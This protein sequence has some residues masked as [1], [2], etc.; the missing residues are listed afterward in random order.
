[1]EG[2]DTLPRRIFL[3]GAR[4]PHA[5]PDGFI[6]RAGSVLEPRDLLAEAAVLVAGPPW[7]GKT[8]VAKRLSR[9]LQE[10]TSFSWLTSFDERESGA[11]EPLWW[12][13]WL[14]GTGSAV[15]IIDA[16]D[17]DARK[18]RQCFRI[19]RSIR[20]LSPEIRAR[21]HLIAFCRINE[22]PPGFERDLEEIFGA[23]RRVRLAGLDRDAAREHVGPGRFRRVCEL[24]RG[25]DLQP[26]APYPAVLTWLA[27]RGEGEILTKP[28]VWEGVLKDLLREKR[29]DPA[30][31]SFHVEIGERLG[32]ACKLAALTTFCGIGDVDPEE[33][34]ERAFPETAH[35]FAEN[36]RAVREAWRGSLFERFGRGYRFCQDHVRQWLTAFAL[37]EM[38]PPQLKPLLTLENGDPDPS[39]EGV[40][41]LLA[42]ISRHP[43]VKD[44]LVAAHGGL[45]VG[46]TPWSLHEASRAL[47][48]LQ[49]L[50]RSSPWGLS[51]WRQ[52]GLKSFGRVHGMGEEIAR[53]LELDLHPT[54]QQLLLELA[55]VIDAPE[56]VVPAAQILQD[57]RQEE[58][59]RGRAASLVAALGTAEQLG[60]LEV[61][62][63]AMQEYHGKAVL[64]TLEVAFYN[65]GLWGFEKAA[66]RALSGNALRK[67][68]L[69]YVLP[70][71]PVQ[72]DLRSEWL[73]HS[74]VADLTLDRARWLLGN[75]RL[76]RTN[77]QL[78]PL[79]ASALAKVLEQDTPEE[80]D[81]AILVPLL[82]ENA[83]D[84]N[85]EEEGKI[86][87]FLGRSPETRRALFQEGLLRD[88]QGEGAETW[89][90]S[91]VL[92]GEDVA[93][94]LDLFRTREEQ[95]DWLLEPLYFTAYREG[96]TPV[97]RRRVR[98]ELRRADAERLDALDRK[99][100]SWRASNQAWRRREEG[101]AP[102]TFELAPLVREAL[103]SA[104]IELRHK[105]LNLSWYCFEPPSQR[106]SNLSGRW[107]DLPAE[108]RGEVLAVCREA[109][110]QCSATPIPDG[111]SYSRWTSWEA[112]C[113]DRLL[114]EDA[115]FVLTPE[116]I[117]KWLPALLR[118][119]VSGSG[120]EPAL[121]RCFEVD[122]NL[123]EGLFHETVRRS[124]LSE[125]ST[126]VLQNLPPELWSERF[127]GLLEAIVAAEEAV[128]EMRI[129]LLAQIGKVFPVR[130][131]PI[132]LAWAE[133]PDVPLREAGIDL[134]LMVAP[135]EG[136]RHLKEHL[137][138]LAERETPK[139]D[140][141]LR[142]RSLLPH[143]YGPSAAFSS[144]PA[145]QLAE[146]E[147]LLLSCVP[148]ESDPV[149]EEGEGR[150][151]GGEN[152]LRAVRDHLPQLLY[153]RDG[154]G[155]HEALE[156]LAAKHR[157]IR[158]WLDDVR[159]HQGAESV[160]AGLGRGSRPPTGRRVPPA[161]LLNLLQHAE[162]RLLGSADDL[163]DALLEELGRIQ[164]DARQHLSMLY[165]PQPAKGQK[166]E[167]LHED[168]LQAY[169][170]CRLADRLPRVLGEKGLKVE[171]SVDRETL[172][173]GNTRNDLKIQSPSMDGS[174]LTVIIEIKWSSNAKVRTSL[175][176][177]LGKDYLLRNGLTHGIYLV[178]WNGPTTRWPNREAC[179]AELLEQAQRF[180]AEHPG[181]HIDAFVMD[182]AV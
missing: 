160:I 68:L 182:L 9:F 81:V 51:V 120:Y 156:A 126:Y 78:Y 122:R 25:N 29:D 30:R 167:H 38:T 117:E 181:R 138:A 76:P 121:R 153:Q 124:V 111:S 145:V 73:Q 45:P 42:Q 65:K 83:N 34:L 146:L 99:R 166:R 161:D 22:I 37:R 64:S 174:R 53:R 130:A 98:R 28:D 88:P 162:H 35:G 176:G 151:L 41:G 175:A 6:L 46:D 70:P 93:W 171:P 54:E 112:A 129:D 96:A 119:W 131:R 61:W 142:M 144:W 164:L 115:A 59:V 40:A 82:L 72:Y 84:A 157:R 17:E 60:P 14:G 12:P 170:A 11:S 163:Q 56:P 108:L 21:L 94:L 116:M 102:P 148:S 155:D 4:E 177:Q 52:E 154:E 104:E 24:V 58:R 135:E 66:E 20:E 128:R 43:E 2:L 50:A 8:T 16:V 143:H 39:H 134:L 114:S 110:A 132:A 106:P 69:K 19:L 97:V 173:A 67:A 48:T 77:R 147:E 71:A 44:W 136:W 3:E 36:R 141:F 26:L 139:K 158:E 27:E 79:L 180:R 55:L 113:F 137:K 15:W 103:D 57:G 118:N 109:L 169:L 125:K 13:D 150:S 87:R 133:G 140:V 63:E 179:R 149:W 10:T 107:E 165:R 23:L 86:R 90:W 92:N 89:V 49:D 62:V 95:Q 18:D 5:D 1:V 152:D 159:A 105:M 168:A 101:E 32:V 75:P 123:A 100:R 33:G 74:L 127:S 172:A 47:D 80:A 91:S 31:P 178:G 7:I 85:F